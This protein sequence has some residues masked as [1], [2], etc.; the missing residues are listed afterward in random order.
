MS[1]KS[2]LVK[3]QLEEAKHAREASIREKQAAIAEREAAQAIKGAD[4]V[5]QPDDFSLL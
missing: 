2:A 4:R 1:K 5:K 3:A